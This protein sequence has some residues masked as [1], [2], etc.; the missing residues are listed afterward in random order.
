[1][2]TGFIYKCNNCGEAVTLSGLFEYY[3]DESGRRK[4][5]GH[6][7]QSDKA[8]QNGVMGFSVEWYCCKCQKVREVV[9]VEYSSPRN[10]PLDSCLAYSDPAVEHKYFLAVCNKCNSVLVENLN[11]LPCPKC[12][13]GKFK[14]SGRFMS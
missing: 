14:E 8:K 9:V 1:M 10:D 6:L 2:P 3:I 13:I 12:G 5:Y 7:N 11:G 4:R